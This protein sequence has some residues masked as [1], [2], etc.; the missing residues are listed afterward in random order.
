MELILGVIVSGLQEGEEYK[1]YRYSDERVVPVSSFNA[2][3]MNATMVYDI[4]GDY[5]GTFVMSEKILSDEKVIYRAV[6]ANAS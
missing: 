3:S 6:P 2:E 1:L 4:V 5:T